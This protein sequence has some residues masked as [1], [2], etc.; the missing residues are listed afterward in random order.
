MR[1][2]QALVQDQSQ[3]LAKLSDE[4]RSRKTTA[5]D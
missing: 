2:L 1:E 4:V 3:I 5:T